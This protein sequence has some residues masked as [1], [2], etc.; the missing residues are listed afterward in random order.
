MRHHTSMITEGT[1]TESKGEKG[2]AQVG[3]TKEKEGAVH[4]KCPCCS[5]RLFD[6]E[7][8]SDA[9]I[10]IKCAKCGAV[11]SVSMHHRKFRCRRGIDTKA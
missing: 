11:V 5:Q 7:K 4:V 8:D 6:M 3:D 10:S 9:V 1:L 2:V